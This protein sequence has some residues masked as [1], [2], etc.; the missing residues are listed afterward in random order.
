[1]RGFFRRHR[2]S[3]K[4]SGR[5]TGVFNR[6]Q[7]P[8]RQEE[9]PKRQG[10]LKPKP[11]GG[12]GNA[13]V[14]E[15]LKRVQKQK[16]GAGQNQESGLFRRME[17]PSGEVMIRKGQEESYPQLLERLKGMYRKKG[18]AYGDVIK[19]LEFLVRAMNEK[20]TREPETNLRRFEEM[21]LH[22]MDLLAAC[23]TAMEN[24]GSSRSTKQEKQAIILQIQNIAQNDLLRLDSACTDF[25]AMTP[26]EQESQSWKDVLSK[27]R[28][29]R[30]VTE[31]LFHTDKEKEGVCSE[32]FRIS[33]DNAKILHADQ[34]EQELDRTY[35]FKEEDAF[36]FRSDEE[37]L[38]SA[39]EQARAEGKLINDEDYKNLQRWV[40]N[41]TFPNLT[42]EGCALYAQLKKALS[43]SAEN[44]FRE[45]VMKNAEKVM[46]RFPQLSQEEKK[47]V[48]NWASNVNLNYDSDLMSDSEIQNGIHGDV[49]FVCSMIY[50]LS[51]NQS[52]AMK[53]TLNQAGIKQ[54]PG[55]STINTTRRNVATSR[56][57]A[58]LGLQDLVARSE[59]V[60]IHDKKSEQTI[61]GNLMESAKGNL[62]LKKYSDNLRK[63]KKSMPKLAG[64]V[65]RE[66]MSLQVLDVLCGQ[67]DRHVGNIMI[68]IKQGAGQNT[69]V[70]TGV[71]AFDNDAA[72]GMNLDVSTVKHRLKFD[73]RVYDPKTGDLVIPYMDAALAERILNLRPAV[74]GFA[75]N[76]LL[77]DAE[78][79]MTIKRLQMMQN[80]IKKAKSLERA[81]NVQPGQ[82]RFRK[83]DEWNEETLE[84][85][86]SADQTSSEENRNYVGTVLRNFEG[87]L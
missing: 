37:E 67:V 10:A 43:V 17:M 57:A 46:K 27:V 86:R 45:L 80:A 30:I 55:A 36:K 29:V 7:M 8:D 44:H 51:E 70:I 59:T 72:F 12:V 23:G 18:E 22:Y 31:D 76:G 3:K 42:R 54:K 24:G 15:E 4:G 6:M 26:E 71:S 82:S 16:S 21:K 40:E 64:T 50:Q 68:T 58:L 81:R 33:N 39:L 75:L 13:Q 65:Q 20:F 61:R 77:T 47:S 52:T 32:V 60:E 66:L 79:N 62:D 34:T 53:S 9:L 28:T 49:R 74:L 5:E 69:D 25:C 63:G 48:L 87:C 41:G 2:S 73:R 1:M 38:R 84:R 14:I 83:N 11:V 35:F 78:I 19:S 56:V 85:L